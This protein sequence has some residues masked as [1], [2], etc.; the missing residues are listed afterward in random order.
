MSYGGD[1][2]GSDD[3]LRWRRGRGGTTVSV[4]ETER[5][6]D[7]ENQRWKIDRG[8][9]RIGWVVVGEDLGLL[10]LGLFGPKLCQPIN[11]VV[12]VPALRT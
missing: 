9:D 1:T 6:G 7:A 8:S 12:P 5:G 2:E 10:Y 3:G 4:A 11:S